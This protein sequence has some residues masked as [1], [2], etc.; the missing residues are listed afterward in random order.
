MTCEELRSQ[1]K[2]AMRD[3]DRDRLSAL[4]QVLQAVRQVEV[5]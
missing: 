3:H 4:R 2:N 5:D 1:I